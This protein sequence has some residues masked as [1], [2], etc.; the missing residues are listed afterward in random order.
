MEAQ[1]EIRGGRFVSGF[2][3]E[4]Y[5]RPEAIDLLRT[6]RRGETGLEEQVEV[7]PADPLNLTGI[8]LPGARVSATSISRNAAVWPELP[9]PPPQGRTATPIP[10]QFQPR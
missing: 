1:G 7:S 4:Q 8:I 10:E 6:V 9:A 2:T 3:G 5:A